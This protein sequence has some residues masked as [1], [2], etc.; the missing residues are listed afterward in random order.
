MASPALPF[1]LLSVLVSHLF[2]LKVLRD[3]S[4][5]AQ[6]VL[7]TPGAGDAIRK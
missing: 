4:P 7:A 2:I 6:T 3:L 1:I 5:V